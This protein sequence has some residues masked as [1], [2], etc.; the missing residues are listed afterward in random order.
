[1]VRSPQK[2]MAPE[3]TEY[4]PPGSSAVTA[5]AQTGSARVIRTLREFRVAHEAVDAGHADIV[6]GVDFIAHQ[7]RGNPGFLGDRHIAGAGA[8][9]TDAAFAVNGAVA[10]E[11]DGASDHRVFAAG[12]LGGHGRGANRVGPG[13]QNV[14][15]IP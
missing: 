14:A 15:R 2:R 12:Q 1:M 11:T 3:S 9:H 10:P 6:D 8:D 5:A 4:S 13:D 7:F